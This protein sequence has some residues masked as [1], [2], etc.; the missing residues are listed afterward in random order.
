VVDLFAGGILQFGEVDGLDFYF[1][2]SE[3]NYSSVFSHFVIAT[4]LRVTVNRS[5]P[6][7]KLLLL[8]PWMLCSRKGSAVAALPFFDSFSSELSKRF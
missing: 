5:F 2:L 4:S 3:K 7:K 1:V 8:L 6:G